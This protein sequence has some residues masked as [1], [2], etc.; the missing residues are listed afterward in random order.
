ME[1]L[2]TAIATP[3]AHASAQCIDVVKYGI[4][5][6]V[7]AWPHEKS[8]LSLA[9][10]RERLVACHV[11]VRVLGERLGRAGVILMLDILMLDTS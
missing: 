2:P 9:M 6:L 7:R 11:C 5:Q 4:Q 8:V 3:W 10:K 1:S